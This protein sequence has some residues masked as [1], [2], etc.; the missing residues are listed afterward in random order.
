VL[1]F[2]H[3]FYVYETYTSGILIVHISPQKGT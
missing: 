1:T 2:S 3:G